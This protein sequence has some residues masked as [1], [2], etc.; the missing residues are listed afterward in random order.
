[1]NGEDFKKIDY[2]GKIV[3]I[4][5]IIDPRR[6]KNKPSITNGIFIEIFDAPTKRIISISLL[7]A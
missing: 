2:S 5:G 6:P 4:I 3:I 1:M 7:L